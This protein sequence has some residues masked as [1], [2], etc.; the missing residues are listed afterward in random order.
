MIPNYISRSAWAVALSFAFLLAAPDQSWSQQANWTLE[1]TVRGRRISGKPVHWSTQQVT[2]LGRDGYLWDFAP[3]EATDFRK[4]NHSFRSLSQAEMRAALLRE[5]GR[6]FDVSGTGHYLV[7]HPAGARDVWAQR[8]E[9]LYRDFMLYFAARGFRPSAPEFPL[10]AVVFHKQRDFQQFAA[11][12][13]VRVSNGVLGYYSPTTN[14]VLLYDVTG[15]NSSSQGWQSNAETIIHEATHQTAF[16]TGVHN[17]LVQVPRWLAEGLAT[18]FEAPGVYSSRQHRQLVDRINRGRLQQYRQINARVSKTGIIQAL[19]ESDQLFRSN[20]AVA[21]SYAWALSFY[22]AERQPREYA[23]YLTL[24]TNLPT[25][26]Q[27]QSGRLMDTGLK[28]RNTIPT[29]S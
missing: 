14:R 12:E 21:Y 22:L 20:P 25:N 27:R 11:K 2:V 15:G 19:V 23:Q 29:Y 4:T 9:D 3:A 8:F 5:F 26:G 16:N 18:M 1:A 7:V 24:T 10:V 28:D 13:D 17:R 6:S